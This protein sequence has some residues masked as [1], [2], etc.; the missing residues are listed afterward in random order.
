MALSLALA[1]ASILALA[2]AWGF[3]ELW[4]KSYDMPDAQRLAK[5]VE[6]V[7]FVVAAYA[8][9]ELG[10]AVGSGP[11]S[12]T[13]LL[14]WV[15]LLPPAFALLWCVHDLD[16]RHVYTSAAVGSL[17]PMV[18]RAEITPMQAVVP[19]AMALLVAA[20]GARSEL[21]S[22]RFRRY[23]CMLRSSCSCCGYKQKAVRELCSLGHAGEQMV[24]EYLHDHRESR[25]ESELLRCRP[26]SGCS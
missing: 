8:V 12:A 10:V 14:A 23:S 13:R 25:V 21:A 6:A 5:A 26:T 19:A 1:Y 9:A 17:F 22:V 24:R 7:I 15:G 4:A 3:A 11:L 16:W 20:M 18:G 2:V